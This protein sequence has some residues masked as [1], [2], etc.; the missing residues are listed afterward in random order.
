MT[1]IGNLYLILAALTVIL[2]AGCEKVTVI[3]ADVTYQQYYVVRAELKAFSSFE[4]V[5][6]TKTLPLNENYDIKNAELKNVTAYLKINGIQV[7]PLH[8]THDGIYVPKDSISIKP[9]TT[10]ELFASVE[11]TTIYA[12]TRVPKT[13]Q[14]ISAS[15]KDQRFVEVQIQPE[16]GAVYG[17]FWQ[18]YNQATG[19]VFDQATDFQTIEQ[20]SQTEYESTMTVNT[21]D[22]PDNYIN[23]SYRNSIYA[24]VYAFDN[25]YLAYFK[26]KNNNQPSDNIF[27]QG[28]D[29]V[30]WNVQGDHVIGLFI[31]YSTLGKVKAN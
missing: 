1:R 30:A 16:G 20:P 31:G 4:G 15:L 7:I 24:S 9:A 26:S 28:G 8:Y 17:A 14:V 21:K 6:F 25:D 29:Q 23:G 12:M 18:I 19:R 2:C 22:L 3:S 11:N 27:A 13:P 10:Y 5:T